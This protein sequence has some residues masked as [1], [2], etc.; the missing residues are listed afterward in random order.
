MQT[1]LGMH[2]WTDLSNQPTEIVTYRDAVAALKSNVY[3][4]D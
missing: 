1:E 4:K 3:E 2:R